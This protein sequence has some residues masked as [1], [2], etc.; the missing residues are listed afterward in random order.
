MAFKV[1]AEFA[2]GFHFLK[3]KTKQK[4]QRKNG[5]ETPPKTEQDLDWQ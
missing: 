4:K 5:K 3:T 2:K 1:T